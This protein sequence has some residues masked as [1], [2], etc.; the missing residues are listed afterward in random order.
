MAT[1][2]KKEGK[3]FVVSN[4]EQVACPFCAT[5][6]SSLLEKFGPDHMYSYVR[7]KQCQLAYMNPRPQY[8]ADFVATAYE[9]YAD[10][11]DDWSNPKFLESAENSRRMK[12]NAAVLKKI[13]DQLNVEK[14]RLLEIGCHLGFFG[15]AA[16]EQ[17]F[18]YIGVEVSKK[19]VD[20]ARDR[21]GLDARYGDWQAMNWT[22][23]K[24]DVI[25]CSHVIEHIPNP[26][27]WLERFQ[28]M[29]T[30][31]GVL[32][33]EVPNMD[34][35][36]RKFKRVLK[37]LG[38]RKD[39]WAKWRTPDHLFEPTEPALD[40]VFKKVGLKTNLKETYSFK[41][42]AKTSAQKFYYGTLRAGTNLRYFLRSDA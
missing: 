37:R 29:L 12:R 14:P 11:R 4:W 21:F 13:N 25:Y 9:D 17:G 26:V 30:A 35:P 27:E 22:G 5:N 36:D 24:F 7:C 1:T 38:V 28:K 41:K 6:E 23:Q 15:K 34:S 20:F 33:I 39:K 10:D 40:Y 16:V 31:Q 42:D 8:D 32:V 3:E 19:M 2:L 18:N